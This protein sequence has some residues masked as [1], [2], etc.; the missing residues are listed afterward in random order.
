MSNI[1]IKCLKSKEIKSDVYHGQFVINSLKT[2]QGLTI[3][4]QLRRVLL[5]ICLILKKKLAGKL[6]EW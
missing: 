2:G 5:K 4:N 1:T 6:L 3:G